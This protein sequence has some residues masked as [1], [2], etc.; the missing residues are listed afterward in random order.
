[1]DRASLLLSRPGPLHD[2]DVL[3]LQEM[4]RPGTEQLAQVLGMNYVYVP[5]A[6]HPSSHREMGVAVLSSW[7]IAEARKVL[8]PHAHRIRK[9]RRAAAMATIDTPITRLRVYGVHLE[10][11]LGA[12]DQDRRDQV[13][14]VLND[15]ADWPGAMVIAGDFNGTAAAKELANA[16]FQWLT[17]D[18]HH[19]SWLFDF[20]HILVRGLCV[21]GDPPAAKDTAVRGVSDHHPVW[22]LVNGC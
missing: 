19:T 18:V 14:A 22:A 17:R 4:D 20:D 3:V 12:S 11:P 7:P 6:I 10:T 5:S 16:G 2:A 13:D 8:L 15:A 9:M 1:V 21:S